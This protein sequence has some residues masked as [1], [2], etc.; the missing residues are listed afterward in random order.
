MCVCV[1]GVRVCMCVYG[2]EECVTSNDSL[3]YFLVR[4]CIKKT[5]RLAVDNSVLC[6]TILDQILFLF[7]F[8]VYAEDF[9]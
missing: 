1:L 6:F 3:T 4:T 9:V 5:E 7:L 8:L 2:E